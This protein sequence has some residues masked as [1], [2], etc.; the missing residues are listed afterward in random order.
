MYFSKAGQQKVFEQLAADTAG[1]DKKHTRLSWKRNRTSAASFIQRSRAQAHCES[2]GRVQ[3]SYLF[4]APGKR[5]EGTLQRSVP[6]HLL[7]I[8]ER[9]VVT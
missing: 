6:C 1:T 5:S 9:W 8:E 2:K 3:Y 4:D 7:R